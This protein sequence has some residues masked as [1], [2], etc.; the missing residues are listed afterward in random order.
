ML[1]R[2]LFRNKFS[3]LK[4]GPFLSGTGY[5]L[6]RFVSTNEQFKVHNET[7]TNASKKNSSTHK[8]NIDELLKSSIPELSFK[9]TMNDDFG[10]EAT[11]REPS[12]RE[13]ARGIREFGTNAG[14][15]VNVS[16]K[17][18][19]KAFTQVKRVVNENKI[20]YLQK[21]QSRYIRPAKYRKQLK[22]EWWRRKFLVGF[23]DLLAQ[24][25]DARRRG[26]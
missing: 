4:L 5:T 12:P 8:I 22:R 9:D 25:N 16:Y 23:K 13:V 26:Y 19:P 20:R 15:S 17:N 2:V 7:R 3:P 18:I 10:F 14:R 21:V 1:A 24:V 6:G 11:S